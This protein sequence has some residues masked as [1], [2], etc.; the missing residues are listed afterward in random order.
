MG[1]SDVERQA[2][3]DQIRSEI[4]TAADR[5]FLEEFGRTFNDDDM[6][7]A[8]LPHGAENGSSRPEDALEQIRQEFPLL[9]GED[10]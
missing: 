7:R 8:R 6:K 2:Y 4:E 3:L 9:F 10:T 1:L 5:V